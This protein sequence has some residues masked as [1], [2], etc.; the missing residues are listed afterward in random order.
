LCAAGVSLGQP[1]AT[2][3]TARGQD[4][5]FWDLFRQGGFMMWVMLAVSMF[6]L[7]LIIECAAKLRLGIVA[8]SDLYDQLKGLIA[9]GEYQEAWRV[10]SVRPCPLSRVVLGGLERLGEGPDAV[11]AALEDH[12]LKEALM[13]KT[14]VNYLSVI[15]VVSP[16]L[17]LIGTV[18]GMIEAFQA[19][20]RINIHPGLLA[21]AIGKVL[22]ATAFGLFIAVPAFFA[23]YFFRNRA[24]AM[25]VA[26]QDRV[27]RLLKNLPYTQLRG[28]LVGDEVDAPSMT[29]AA[30]AVAAAQCPNCANSI[31]VGAP[32]C[33][34]CGVPIQWT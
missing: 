11:N 10:A 8:P 14:R 28:L 4:T 21:D 32:S 2:A 18:V 24:Q 23:Y 19:I 7:S 15:G 16:M 22:V 26:L 12:A 27:T 29:A 5:T 30:R 33:P 3:A 20:N 6:A 25:I 13:M 1:G 9:G 31:A 17:G 34:S